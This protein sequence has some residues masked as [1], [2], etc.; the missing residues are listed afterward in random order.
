MYSLFFSL[1]SF[2]LFSFNNAESFE[3]N[4]D[5]DISIMSFNIRYDTK[6]DGE[7][8]WSNRK[9]ACVKMLKEITPSVFGIQEGLRHQVNF[10]D[11]K[12]PEYDHVGVGR[13]DGKTSGEFAAIFYLKDRFEIINTGNFW[14]SETPEQPSLG[15]DANNIR[16]V[17]WV[18]LKDLN[19]KNE[20]YVF[21]T[22]FDHMGSEARKESAKL[23]IKRINS[24]AGNDS[25][26]YLCGDFNAL[27]GNDILRPVLDEM[28][29]AQSNAAYSNDGK[30]FNGWGK[31]L[32]QSDIDFIFY[33]NSQVLAFR[34]VVKNYGVPYISDHYPIIAYFDY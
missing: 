28:K 11:E 25:R 13:D 18:K 17:T 14:L 32:H 10:L 20:L 29:E 34:T 8:Q 22:H 6:D 27:L 5:H 33:R 15:W 12:L 19:H 9:A 16:I 31:L 3:W 7:H 2:I 26:V 30:S 23:V 4:S 21:N 1:V 24:I